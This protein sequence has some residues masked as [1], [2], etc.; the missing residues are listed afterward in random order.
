M[1]SLI[2]S[3]NRENHFYTQLLGLRLETFKTPVTKNYGKKAWQKINIL[4]KLFWMKK[5]I[6]I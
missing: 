4:Q 2:F 5:R 6:I 1:F 3:I